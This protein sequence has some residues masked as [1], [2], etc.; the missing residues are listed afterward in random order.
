MG[1][2]MLLYLIA[3]AAVMPALARLPYM[4]VASSTPLSGNSV[5]RVRPSHGYLY[6]L[7]EKGDV[8]VYDAGTKYKTKPKAR[9]V[10]GLEKTGGAKSV[11]ETERHTYIVTADGLS[12]HSNRPPF[13]RKLQVTIANAVAVGPVD[14]KFVYVFCTTG[15]SSETLAVLYKLSKTGLTEVERLLLKK[16]RVVSVTVTQKTVFVGTS[17][18]YILALDP[19]KEGYFQLRATAATPRVPQV[20]T[21]F[22]EF[23]YA[24]VGST[25]RVYLTPS[26]E[27]IQEMAKIKMQAHIEDLQWFGGN[28]YVVTEKRL[29]VVCVLDPPKPFEIGV[30]RLEAPLSIAVLNDTAYIVNADNSLLAIG[31]VPEPNDDVESKPHTLVPKVA[32]SEVFG[33]PEGEFEA[34]ETR[35]GMPAF[36]FIPGS[37]YTH[38]PPFVIS[39]MILSEGKS[40]TFAPVFRLKEG[41]QIK[42]TCRDRMCNVFIHVEMCAPCSSPLNGGL[43]TVLLMEGWYL[44]TCAPKFVL[45]PDMHT[46]EMVTFRKQYRNNATVVLAT[47]TR[48]AAFVGVTVAGG[49]ELCEEI[50]LQEEC[51]GTIMC[52]WDYVAGVCIPQF[53]DST[54]KNDLAWLESKRHCET[55]AATELEQLTGEMEKELEWE[56]ELIEDE[57]RLRKLGDTERH[58]KVLKKLRRLRR[59]R[60]ARMRQLEGEED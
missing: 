59:E 36:P 51:S 8:A 32:R 49:R 10:A 27:V 20:L 48:E 12:I 60:E 11:Q 19:S 46:H 15:D 6:M 35:V 18:S 4:E 3:A 28:V 58:K 7:S 37:K 1:G 44:T 50:Y 2:G 14:D 30:K 26:A 40:R 42:L 23:V 21:S 55:C 25:F 54:C 41:T 43:P 17:G 45:G 34:V 24:G 52:S 9:W 16:G 5:D 31:A 33:A 29:R 39:S 38:V 13:A 56:Q 47:L 57:M 22:L 53:P